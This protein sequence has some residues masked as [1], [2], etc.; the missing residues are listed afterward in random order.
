MKII[1]KRR[2]DKLEQILAEM[3]IGDE[4]IFDEDSAFKIV[5]VPNGYLYYTEYAGVAFVPEAERK[6]AEKPVRRAVTK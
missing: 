4:P 3:K 2:G 1:S 5:R 6:D